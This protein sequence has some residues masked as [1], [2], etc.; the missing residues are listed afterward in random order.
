MLLHCQAAKEVQQ[1]LSFDY[2]AP[3]EQ[4]AMFGWERPLDRYLDPL[5]RA[6]SLKSGN[7]PSEG[8]GPAAEGE[9]VV[10]LERAKECK[11]PA[12]RGDYLQ[13]QVAATFPCQ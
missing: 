9:V 4:Q 3:P 12:I 5:H 1:A 6:F 11:N 8:A 13:R 7:Q 2:Y 10:L